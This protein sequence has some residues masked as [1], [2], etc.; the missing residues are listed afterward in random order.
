[1]YHLVSTLDD[2]MTLLEENSINLKKISDKDLVF[3]TDFLKESFIDSPYGLPYPH[4]LTLKSKD[5]T[6]LINL[7][8]DKLQQLNLSTIK[9]NLSRFCNG[10]DYFYILKQK[11]DILTI[12]D[13]SKYFEDLLIELKNRKTGITMY[14]IEY[15]ST[16]ILSTSD[17]EDYTEEFL[18]DYLETATDILN[19]ENPMQS[20]IVEIVD[21]IVSKAIS[22]M[23]VNASRVLFNFRNIND[24]VSSIMFFR[25]EDLSIYNKG[26]IF[27][28]KEKLVCSMSIGPLKRL[29]HDTLLDN[30][31]SNLPFGYIILSPINDKNPNIENTTR[32]LRGFEIIINPSDYSHEERQ[33]TATE[34]KENFSINGELAEPSEK[35]ILVGGEE[36]DIIM[37]WDC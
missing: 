27:S 4:D 20:G 2:S 28:E 24:E 30:S 34:L 11:G 36:G 3:V 35:E 31:I 16:E 9:N 17:D 19:K 18:F 10:N 7:I 32:E 13:P 5:L 8:C 29:I 25:A 12:V 1:M 15:Y 37:G 23:N 26:L 33:L 21:S 6:N 14:D 22:F